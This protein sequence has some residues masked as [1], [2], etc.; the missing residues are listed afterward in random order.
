MAE[1]AAA[2]AAPVNFDE[3][4]EVTPGYVAPAKVGDRNQS[5]LFI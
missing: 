4:E 5:E 1:E 3:D 2:A